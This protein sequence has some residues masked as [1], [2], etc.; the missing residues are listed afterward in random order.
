M[1]DETVQI[2]KKKL[3]RI[4]IFNGIMWVILIVFVSVNFYVL[5]HLE[6]FC[7]CN[8]N[9]TKM[10]LTNFNFNF[11]GNETTTSYVYDVKF[12]DAYDY[13]FEKIVKDFALSHN[14]S[15]NYNCV[16]YSRD[17]SD[18]LSSK[19]YYA[20]PVVGTYNNVG[21]EWVRLCL[22]IEPITGNI[23]EKD[24]YCPSYRSG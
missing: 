10:N 11:S 9:K 24:S 6:K 1:E 4:R 8:C 15:D 17:L 14:Y 3:R 13:D 5:G 18:L 22:N 12:M 2:G 16:Q 19:G 20:Y 23:C 7:S 21:H